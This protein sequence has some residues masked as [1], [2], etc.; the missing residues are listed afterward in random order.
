MPPVESSNTAQPPGQLSYDYRGSVRPWDVATQVICIG[1]STVCI[2]MR[3]YSKLVLT[4]SPGWEDWLIGYAVITFKADQHGSGIHQSEVE[5]GDLMEYAKVS[6]KRFPMPSFNVRIPN[7]TARIH[8][9]N[10][11]RPI[12]LHNK[13][14]NPPPVPPSLHTVIQKQDLLLHS[15]THLGKLCLLPNK[16]DDQDLSMLA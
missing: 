3:M 15:P 6:S 4:R 10:R 11:L 13:A 1:V 9:A 5:K 12:N 7:G 8:F 2:S 16:H 14:I